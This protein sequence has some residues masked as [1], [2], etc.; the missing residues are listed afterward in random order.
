MRRR[1]PGRRLRWLLLAVAATLVLAFVLVWTTPLFA[2]KEVR[3]SGTGVLDP[4]EVAE[5][6]DEY[7]DR[8]ILRADLEAIADEVASLP[9]VKSVRVARSWP[10]SV[11]IEVTER[12]PYLAVPSGDETFLMV[13]SEGVVFDRVGEISESIWKVELAEPGPDD[14]ATLE[15][16]A[17]LQA[18]PSGLADEVERVSTPSPA[19]VTLQLE[20]GRTLVWG[21]GS[22]NDK[23]ARVADRLLASGY[24]HVDVSAPDAP[25]VS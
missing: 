17:V 5:A 25:T 6:A 12:D 4:G 24:E 23:K 18:L 16:L 13:D 10:R 22:Q 2:L 3:V 7:L 20:G 1:L 19:A 9:A 11:L 21:D 8:S 14:L 15:T